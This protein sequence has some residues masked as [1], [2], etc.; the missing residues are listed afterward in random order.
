MPIHDRWEWHLPRSHYQHY[1]GS[2]DTG[3]YIFNNR[4]SSR[5]FSVDKSTNAFFP[6]SGMLTEAPHNK[7]PATTCL[8]LSPHKNWLLSW[9]SIHSSLYVATT[10]L[11]VP[12]GLLHLSI[13]H[14]YSDCIPWSIEFFVI[15]LSTTRETYN[16]HIHRAHLLRAR[17][18]WEWVARRTETYYLSYTHVNVYIYKERS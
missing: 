1:T 13:S 17:I 5:Q 7:P 8:T 11:L 4:G 9:S 14:H 12:P 18:L 6:F 16:H 15:S 2:F 3:Y 10:T